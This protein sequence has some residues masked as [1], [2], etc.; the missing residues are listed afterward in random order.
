MVLLDKALSAAVVGHDMV[1]NLHHS[2]TQHVGLQLV[3]PV[4]TAL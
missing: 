1:L 4:K 2:L 3:F